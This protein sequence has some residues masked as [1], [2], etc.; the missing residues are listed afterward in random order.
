M[1]DTLGDLLSNARRAQGKTLADAEAATRIR[2]K[3]I[4]ALE[5]CDYDVLPNP[6]YVR[7]YIISLAKF[8]ELDPAPLLKKFSDES[9]HRSNRE[10]MRLPEQVVASREQTHA[11][12]ARA[13][14]LIAG[15]VVAVSLVIWGISSFARGPEELPPVPTVPESSATVEPSAAE[16]TPA[17]A[18]D[19]T[20]PS[21]DTTTSPA[22]T[23]EP[24]TLQVEIASGGASWLRVTI[25]G[26]KAYEGTL[27][28]RQSKQ[29]EVLD[30]ASVRIGQPSAVTILRD[31]ERLEIPNT[32]ETPV[33]TITDT[34][35]PDTP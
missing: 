30:E 13:A 8:Y 32:A 2:G 28:G 14:L 6:A 19:P 16:T 31:G 35:P 23:G 11:V 20:V 1:G 24:F 10:R 15:V 22:N 12:P 3:L 9:G 5:K 17:P 7:G 27:T 34:Q 25:D 26:L 4:D 18:N 21:A 33:M 29:W